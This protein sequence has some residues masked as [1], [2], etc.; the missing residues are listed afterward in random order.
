MLIVSGVV[1]IHWTKLV[2]LTCF[3]GM[4]FFAGGLAYAKSVQL[5]K[6]V[7]RRYRTR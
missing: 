3:F 6:D 4:F 2:A 1:L 7:I 5:K